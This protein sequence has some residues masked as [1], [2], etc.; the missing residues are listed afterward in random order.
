MLDSKIQRLKDHFGITNPEDWQAVE[1]A[2]VL[3]LDGIGQVTLEYLRLLL[4]A[5]GLTLK[6]DRTPEYWQ[7]HLKSVRISHTLGNELVSDDVDRGIVCPFT[8]LVDTAEQHPFG[9]QG[10]TADADRG[11]RPWIVTTES[12][13]LGRF[14]DSL[15]D[16]SLDCGLNR[17]H[18]ERK[19]MQDA[20]STILGWA[21]KGEDGG[22]RERFEKEL[23][24]LSEIEAGLVVVECDYFELIAKAPQYGVK[25]AA[26]NA[27]TLMRSVLAWQQ[28]YTVPWMF[29]SSR[30]LAEQV[31]FRWLMR[32]YEKDAARRK[33]EAKRLGQVVQGGKRIAGTVA[34]ESQPL[35]PAIEGGGGS[36]A[37]DLAAL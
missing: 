3:S 16:Y 13:A 10:F 8:V 9:F 2:W 20:H 11:N 25:T 1:P 32:W 29:C 21:K 28:D 34:A 14:P 27:R 19:S 4:A 18:V 35:L 6:N 26:Q 22:R 30:R 7:Q 5:R 15:G 17:C 33:A 36:L 23:E 31:T 24:R 37:A 12:V